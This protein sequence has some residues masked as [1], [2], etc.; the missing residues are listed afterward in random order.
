MDL[1][2]DDADDEVDERSGDGDDEPGVSLG[3][4]VLEAVQRRNG[5]QA[6]DDDR[7]QRAEYDHYLSIKPTRRF[8][9]D[10]D[11][12]DE[13]QHGPRDSQLFQAHS[14]HRL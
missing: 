8:H 9:T 2:E 4:V 11:W 10:S 3:C 5:R 6:V 1:A 13:I 7:K 14:H 12:G